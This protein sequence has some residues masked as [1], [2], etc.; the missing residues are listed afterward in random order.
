MPTL[1]AQEDE[2]GRVDIGLDGADVGVRVLYDRLDVGYQRFQWQGRPLPAQDHPT[3]DALA[4]LDRRA[5]PA[6]VDTV[7]LPQLAAPKAGA[8]AL[9]VDGPATAHYR[10]F[11]TL[12]PR[13]AAAYASA[14]GETVG[15]VERAYSKRLDQIAALRRARPS[16]ALPPPLLKLIVP[17]TSDVEPFHGSNGTH[18][19]AVADALVALNE[20]WGLFGGFAED[21]EV[22]VETAS[23]RLC[24]VTGG[25]DATPESPTCAEGKC[26]P[27]RVTLPEEG[28]DP[29]VDVGP[30][31][32]AEA[33][34]NELLDL[35][36]T[37]PI[38]HGFDSDPAA[39]VFPA[40]SFV[41][42]APPSAVGLDFAKL[43]LRRWIDPRYIRV[44]AGVDDPLASCAKPGTGVGP[45]EIDAASTGVHGVAVVDLYAAL[46]ADGS[47]TELRVTLPGVEKAFGHMKVVLSGSDGGGLGV[48]VSYAVP[49]GDV[50]AYALKKLAVAGAPCRVRVLLKRLLEAPGTDSAGGGDAPPAWELTVYAGPTGGRVRRAATVRL[51]TID[52]V[53]L[54]PSLGLRVQCAAGAVSDVILTAAP[55]VSAYAVGEWMQ[56]LPHR[57]VQAVPGLAARLAL[58]EK[59]ASV[60]ATPVKDAQNRIVA[61]RMPSGPRL[62]SEPAARGDS[63]QGLVQRI[64]VVRMDRDAGGHPQPTYLGLLKETGP[65]T[66]EFKE[67]GGALTPAADIRGIV[68]LVR[69]NVLTNDAGERTFASFDGL[70]DLA[71]AS[72][73][74]PANAKLDTARDAA[75]ALVVSSSPFR[76]RVREG[77]V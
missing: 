62:Q 72:E 6:H 73:H 51:R 19:P 35:L 64:A 54:P 24:P 66:Y 23:R 11:G 21:L 46:G 52:G 16:G 9:T 25:D 70:A 55:V 39:A 53:V 14:R 69:L 40:T 65:G 41:V 2:E 75:C 43:Q 33:Q 15:T 77:A 34:K 67:E 68:L 50:W 1:I 22:A 60:D 44:G 76:I 30:M 26:T 36:V 45:W 56:F 5:A 13:Y 59:G 29:V 31:S 4:Y 10:V 8:Y 3:W 47:P 27:E 32:T 20:Q 57:D 71:A 63:G 74:V 38:G 18:V 42:H 37:G 7:R 61:L 17:L 12:R 58:P 48:A 49:K 28:H